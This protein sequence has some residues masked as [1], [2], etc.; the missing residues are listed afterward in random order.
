MQLA[1]VVQNSSNAKIGKVSTTYQPTTHCVDCPLKGNGCYA[2]AGMVAMH[3]RKLDDAARE[4]H[5]SPTRT[6]RQEARG[7]RALKARGQGLRL[8]TSGDCPSTEA[9]EIV[10][11]AAEEFM[12]RGGGRA[13]TYTHAWRRVSRKAWGAVSVLA[14]VETLSD[15]RRAIR[16]GWAVARVV[17]TFATEKAWQEGGIRWIPC[18]AQTRDDVTC[19]SCRLCWDD[20]KLRAIGAGVAFEAH[21]SSKRRAAA[22]CSK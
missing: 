13:W 19:E 6:A 5:A 15:A 18:P 17:P 14:S 1:I 21:G 22:A 7:I 2:Q 8:H 11:D 3:T 16:N 4:S 20:N 9:A 10:A 12:A